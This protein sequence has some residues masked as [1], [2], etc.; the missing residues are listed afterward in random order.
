MISFTQKWITV[1]SIVIFTVFALYATV[2]SDSPET[3]IP[4]G[5]RAFFG[6]DA[7]RPELVN[8]PYITGSNDITS[9]SGK[10]D[11]MSEDIMAIVG[12]NSTPLPKPGRY[13]EIRGSSEEGFQNLLPNVTKEE[14]AN[15][16]NVYD[17]SSYLWYLSDA[18]IE[19]PDMNGQRSSGL[20]N[21]RGRLNLTDSQIQFLK[22]RGGNA[23]SKT[24]Y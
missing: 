9:S 20:S 12:A 16:D 11:K 14:N 6:G 23:N 21:S 19:T 18:N 3:F 7:Y 8:V 22:S 15:L 2:P 17:K 24:L 13:G 1:L 5:Y 10:I 4:Y